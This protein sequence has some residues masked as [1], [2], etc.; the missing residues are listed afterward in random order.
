MVDTRQYVLIT[1]SERDW[2][3]SL[4]QVR[5]IFCVVEVRTGG[6]VR[7]YGTLSLV[8]QPSVGSDQRHEDHRIGNRLLSRQCQFFWLLLSVCLSRALSWH[9]IID[10][11]QDSLPI[12][13]NNL[14]P[15]YKGTSEDL[16]RYGSTG[17]TQASHKC[18]L[19]LLYLLM[20]SFLSN[21]KSLRCVFC[22]VNEDPH[23]LILLRAIDDGSLESYFSIYIW[24]EWMTLF[25]NDG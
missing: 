7:R 19:S 6:T 1:A 12:T 18:P 9:A 4:W 22:I 17:V 16:W 11:K 15:K 25:S 21:G 3:W 5:C 2:I 13:V 10:R 8:E 14:T 24:I 20:G 23:R